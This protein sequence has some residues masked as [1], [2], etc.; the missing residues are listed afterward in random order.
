[1]VAAIGLLSA[2]QN[3]ANVNTESSTQTEDGTQMITILQ[4]ADIHGQLN[5]H[6]ELFWEN[7]EIVFRRLGG[8]ANMRSLFDS[9][10]TENPNGTL[11]LDGGDLIQG[12]AVAAL[13][14]GRA[15]P[16]IVRQ[17]GYDFLIPGNW[18]VV[19]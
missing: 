3:T 14:E 16:G 2:C 15:F 4:T 7:D 1:L 8:M 17:M 9:V 18:E 11:I 12:G 13:S 10:K 19:Y 5:V 6:D